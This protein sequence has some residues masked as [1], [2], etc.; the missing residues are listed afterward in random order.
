[1]DTQIPAAE[2]LWQAQENERMRLILET[3][4]DAV[5]TMNSA[6]LITGWNAEAERM[7]GW[8]REEVVGRSMTDTII[9]P[10]YREA[11]QQGLQRFLD[12]GES[13]M[14]NRRIEITALNRAGRAFPVELAISPAKLADTWTFSAFLRDISDRKQAEEEREERA[15]LASLVVEIRYH[16]TQA[17]TTRQGLQHC[18]EAFVRHLD[19]A[20][21]RI[22][23]LN[24]ETQE[25][26]LEA[27]A[28]TC[29]DADGARVPVARLKIERI[30]QR[31]KPHLSNDAANDPEIVDPAWAKREGIT[32]LAGYPLTIE[33]RVV[34]VL[35][36]FSR[37][38]FSKP[39]FEGFASVCLPLEQ[40]ILAQR[41]K[42]AANRAESD[43]G[44]LRTID[45]FQKALLNSVSHNL[46][47]PLASIIGALDSVL[48]DGALLDAATQ[49]SLLRTAQGEAKRL[50]WLVQ[51]LLDMTRL[52]G[53]AIR[54]KKE[55]CDL[56]D[57]VGAAL[58]QLGEM[59][60]D[61][62]I[63]V[64]ILPGLP[65][66]PMD[67]VL[68]VQVL[69]NV[70]DNALKYSPGDAPI[71][72]EARVYAGQL[73][74]RVLDRGRGIPEE[75]LERV[76]E[77]FF[78]GAAPGMP[79]GAGLG[80]SICRGFVEAHGGQMFAKGRVLGGTEIAFFLPV[81][82]KR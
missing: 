71:E 54:V 74:I 36:A 15:R 58:H 52:E 61:R 50:N 20:L 10:Q 51:N 44:E 64:Q 40:F 9:P 66:V 33:D 62:P 46:R 30:A 43:S 5:V 57:V 53:G 32:G 81:D 72:I 41:A 79:R 23:T 69:V 59:D 31:S 76:F 7:F 6:G 19:A 75:E 8:F 13:R 63:S 65:L 39:A 37:K 17:E 60:R 38:P 28:G 2:L 82:P 48:E 73:E 24:E 49:Q 26:E 47:T 11:H 55:P 78:R 56:H 21:V 42:K 14:S 68:I 35:S 77:K 45:K 16:L 27:G 3:A 22:W 18:T 29:H 34:G 12:T 4:L 80:L 67:Y 70:L 25:L 1:M